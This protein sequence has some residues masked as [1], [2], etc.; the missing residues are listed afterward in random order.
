M[1]QEPKVLVVH[2]VQVVLQVLMEPKER[3]ELKV[4]QEPKVLVVHLVH[5]VQQ[6]LVVHL[7]LT[8]LKER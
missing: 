5:Q 1:Q 4:Q 7:V 8:E 6:G 3:Q 2:L